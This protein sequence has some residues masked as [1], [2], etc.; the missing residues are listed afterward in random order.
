MLSGTS[1]AAAQAAKNEAAKVISVN[2]LGDVA[3]FQTSSLRRVHVSGATGVS[4]A[5]FFRGAF[6]DVEEDL[7]DLT[8]PINLSATIELWPGRQGL[9]RDLSL[10]FGTANNL[11]SDEERP[12]LAEDGIWYESDQFVGLGARLGE[13]WLAGLTYSIYTVPVS[14]ID[15]LQEVA[16]SIRYTGSDP[17]GGLSPQLKLAV[18][19]EEKDGAFLQLTGGPSFT[20][21]EG[22]RFPVTLSTPL[23][24]GIGFDDYYGR[25]TETT[26]YIGFGPSASIPL[27]FVPSEQ[28]GSWTL[29]AGVDLLARADGLR[30]TQP[31]FADDTVVAIGSV[32]LSF[33][34]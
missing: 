5:D 30:E 28:Y 23:T 21:R 12:L 2:V 27:P 15:P 31:A 19:V 24:L 29:S 13:N 22:S 6:D 8:F 26:G 10:S 3:S 17:I 11:A 14:D 1:P 20:L 4:T 18:P 33:S 32:L 34:Y 7:D 9:L 25:G 16:V